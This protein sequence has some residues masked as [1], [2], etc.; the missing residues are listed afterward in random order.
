MYSVSKLLPIHRALCYCPENKSLFKDIHMVTSLFFRR[1]DKNG[2]AV[3]WANEQSSLPHTPLPIYSLPLKQNLPWKLGHSYVENRVREVEKTKEKYFLL[4]NAIL[5][6]RDIFF[7][8]SHQC[9]HNLSIYTD[10]AKDAYS[11]FVRC[12][13]HSGTPTHPGPPTKMQGS[14]QDSIIL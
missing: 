13:L 6:Q 9:L 14:F 1:L 8:D 4:A 10:K 2:L 5:A 11:I 12:V 7:L 3:L